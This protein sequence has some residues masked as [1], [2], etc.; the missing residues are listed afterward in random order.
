VLLLGCGG[1]DG[2]GPGPDTPILTRAGGDQ[3]AAPAG[4]ALPQPLSV[5]VTRAG[6]PL[7]G[8]T[9]TWVVLASGG[10]AAPASTVS[11][12]DGIAETSITLPPFA[13]TLEVSAAS[14]GA[15]GSPLRFSATA[16]GATSQAT[17][18][19]VNNEFQPPSLQ[20]R[21]GGS[22]TFVWL[23]GSIQHNVTP[24]APNAIPASVNPAPPALH[25]APYSFV[26]VFPS[27]GTFQYFCGV[28]GSPSAGMRGS[29]TVLP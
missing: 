27:P 13:A 11:G 7:P 14:S 2:P 24:V 20:L 10:S 8:R 6:A 1:G 23:A 28:H 18:Q 19:V 21:S 22:V 25:D 12:S 17:V 26:Q 3:Q 5:R 16:T 15:S 9:V 29:V 4:T